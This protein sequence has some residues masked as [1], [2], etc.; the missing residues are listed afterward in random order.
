MKSAPWIERTLAGVA[1]RALKEFP[2]VVLTGPR[3]S[4][5]T[6]L[7]R[8]Q[9]GRTHRYVSV[10]PPD[11]RLAAVRDPRGFLAQHAPPVILDEVQHAPELLPY[12]K[13]AVDESRRRRGQWVLTG[14]Q[15]LLMLERV[16]ETLA[17]RA[18]ILRLLPFTKRELAG[19]RDRAFP[20]ETARLASPDQDFS[21]LPLWDR[22]LRGFY[23]EIA[24]APERGRDLWHASYQQTYVERDVRSLRQIGD[25]TQFQI[26]CR[27][28]AARAAQ[29][30]DLSALSR[31][32]G[33]AV[34]TV[35]AW[36]TVLEATHQIILLRPYSGNLTKRLVKTPKVHFVDVGTLC[37]LIGLKDPEHAA[38]GPM[39]GAI[40]ENAVVAEIYKSLLHRGEEP[41]LYFWRT[42]TGN[43][44]DLLVETERTLVPIEAKA[45]ATP[46]PEHGDSIRRM[47]ADLGRKSVQPGYVVHAG[48][49]TL[50]LGEGVTA[51]PFA[52]L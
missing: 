43:E 7:L 51:I 16:G 18:A 9:L 20:W 4:G 39:A 48:D 45:T 5:K 33:V 24:L 29:L 12:V 14:S 15:N 1:A 28:L 49:V 17:G 35:K 13:E 47:R 3:Q 8:R 10:E 2:V 41:R 31:E 19:A 42:S 44:V 26:F 32:I 6:S 23:P 38:A 11:V 30:L 22:L 40:F 52:S 34:N 36:V 46:R 21:F 25:L 37:H 27:A 50:P